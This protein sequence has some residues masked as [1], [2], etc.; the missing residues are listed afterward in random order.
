MQVRVGGG[1]AGHS[2]LRL[3]SLSELWLSADTQ[4]QGHTSPC[5]AFVPSLGGCSPCQA[6]GLESKERAEFQPPLAL[7]AGCPSAGN[8]WHQS[9]Q[10]PYVATQR[11]KQCGD[12]TSGLPEEA[13]AWVLVA[14]HPK[15]WSKR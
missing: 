15:C 1:E 10:W 3:A 11:T 4:W 5:G 14:C 9:R 7:L 12:P 8:S 6:Y 13:C 2:P